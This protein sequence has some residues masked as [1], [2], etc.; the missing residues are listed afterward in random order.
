[1]ISAK[2]ESNTKIVTQTPPKQVTRKITGYD[3]TL[4]GSAF[5]KLRGWIRLREG[6]ADAGYIYLTEEDPLP[7]DYLGS[8]EYVVMNQRAAMLDSLLS[9]FKK[10]E[11]SPD[12]I[13][14]PR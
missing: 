2:A 14:R 6:A 11:K 12:Q 9:I 8:T 1:M 5:G 7:K 3:V 4:L 10:R 13:L